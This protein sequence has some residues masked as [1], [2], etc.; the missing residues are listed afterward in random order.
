MLLKAR[1]DG[2]WPLAAV[3]FV[4]VLVLPSQIKRGFERPWE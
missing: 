2:C 3:C 1:K 4:G